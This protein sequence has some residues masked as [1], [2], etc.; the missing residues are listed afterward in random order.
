MKNIYLK[1]L[2]P[3]FLALFS[4]S[5]FSQGTTTSSISGTVLD[6]SGEPAIGAVVKAVHLP[7][8]TTYGSITQV[9]GNYIIPN[10]RVGGPYQ[11]TINY[12]GYEDQVIEGIF[13]QLGQRFRQDASLNSSNTNLDAVIVEGISGSAAADNGVATQITTEQIETLPTLD[14]DLNDFTRA[15]PQASTASSGGVSFAG[16]NN[17]FNAVYIDGAVNNDVFG[18]ADSGTNGGQ[19]GISPISVDAIEQI[20]VVVSPYD[21]KLGGF[22]GGGINAVTRSGTN[23]LE[24]SVYYF[25]Q[26]EDLAGETN[27][28]RADFEGQDPSKLENFSEN[29]YGLRLG[30]PIVKDKAFF[31]VNAEIQD[32]EVPR[33]SPLSI[34]QGDTNTEAEV[35]ELRNFLIDTYGYDPGSFT[36]GPSTL[37]GTKVLGKF[38]LNINQNNKLTARHSYTKG[39]SLSPDLGGT[40]RLSGSNG[41]IFFPSITNSSAIEWNLSNS[42]F[43]NNLTLGY[44]N[45]N[46]NRDPIGERFPYVEIFDGDGTIEFGSEQFST[47]NLLEQDIFTLTNNFNLYKED[48][49]I[50]IGTHN[51]FYSIFNVFLPFNFS[52]WDFESIDDFYAGQAQDVIR[53]YSIVDGQGAVGD[54]S[55]NA[56]ADFNATQLG[57]YIQDEWIVNNDLTLTGGLRFDIPFFNDDPGIADDFTSVTQPMIAAAGWDVINEVENPGQAPGAQVLLSP[58]IGINWTPET[59]DGLT[60]RGGAGIFTSRIPFVWPGA[61]FNTNGLVSDFIFVGSPTFEPDVA[62]QPTDFGAPTPQGDVNLFVEDF[63]Y[64]QMFRTSLGLE[65]TIGNGWNVFVDGIFTKTL[66]NVVYESVNFE[67][68]FRTTPD[69]EA[70]V[71]YTGESVDSRYGA[72]YVGSNTDE[73][74]TYNF[75]G[76]IDK[77]FSDNFRAGAF[78]SYGDA[79]SVNEGTSSQNSSQWRGQI[80]DA[81]GRNNP[82]LGRSDFSVG[83]R[84]VGN[85]AYKFNWNEARNVATT[86]SLFYNG[87]SGTPFSWVVGGN[88]GR[89]ISNESGST[90]RN[91]TLFYIPADASE[92]NLVDDGSLTASEQW[93]L[94]DSF[95]ENDDYLSDNRGQYAEKNSN[96]LPFESILD[97]KVIQDFGLTFGEKY[98]RLQFTADIFNFGNLLNSEWGTNWGTNDSFT[99]QQIL[100]FEGFDDNGSP[101]Y[102]FD[103]TEIGNDRFTPLD[104]SSRWRA[105]VGFRY[106]FD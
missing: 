87:Q 42:N 105:Q 43:S 51:E 24:G 99:Y 72:I 84:V 81:L 5:S 21:V 22:A 75:S 106:L 16:I 1:T 70:R 44:T 94:L 17:R 36:G 79:E 26:N 10:T 82:V 53:V 92:I 52:S 63:K 98:H 32:N 65:K 88:G 77:A 14:R 15:T 30:G 25:F 8:G 28:I 6:E 76:G 40:T 69:A 59:A 45:V 35:T 90:S 33:N 86:V 3:V 27:Q 46:D 66:N 13:L 60:V 48:H 50:T 37:E 31:F 39:E 97:I 57:F 91:R 102:T 103:D 101:T 89:N 9:D 104:V 20:Q 73:G 2:L 93:A 12:I 7:S 56:A 64:P 67:N 54:D 95:I 80:H 62:Q 68:D 41:G 4:L 47:A 100:A 34:Y 78:Y 61:Q 29:V 19:I 38:D 71:I 18:L 58:R 74:Y 55:V 49:T 85:A 23:N 11:L 96:R 83:H